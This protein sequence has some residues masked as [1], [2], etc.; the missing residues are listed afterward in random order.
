[1][2][3]LDSAQLT[4]GRFGAD[5]PAQVALKDLDLRALAA[6][7]QVGCKPET[8]A[9]PGRAVPASGRG[10]GTDPRLPGEAGQLAWPL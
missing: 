2:A 3:C 7:G 10:L 1:M 8:C 9:V 4:A 6:P 5:H